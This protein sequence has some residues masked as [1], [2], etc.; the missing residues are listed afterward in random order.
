MIL[1]FHP[2]NRQTSLRP[3]NCLSRSVFCGPRCGTLY[4]P[5]GSDYS[6]G[7]DGGYIVRRATLDDLVT[8]K[9]LWEINRLPVLELEKRLTEF[10][11][12]LRSDGVVLG[13]IGI[14]QSGGQGLLHS[15]AFYSAHQAGEGWPVLWKRLQATAVSRSLA[16][17]WVRWNGDTR[18][19][20][21]GFSEP[22][23]EELRK[24]PT[25]FT[26]GSSPLL[27][28]RLREESVLP[29]PLEERL[30]LLHSTELEKADRLRR[31]A[32]VFKWIAGLAAIAFF[33]GALVLLLKAVRTSNRRDLR[34]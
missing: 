16:R 22:T 19:S 18:W 9:A 21:L 31:R 30:A 13:A 17:L 1:F 12:V 20:E 11:L 32:V 27:T 23:A 7:V 4:Q 25:G 5:P 29:E 6:W 15:Q 33:C 14:Q 28:L 10:Q 34:R 8:L 24:L 26:A 2:T 3:S